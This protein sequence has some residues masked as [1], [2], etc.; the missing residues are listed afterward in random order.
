M[1]QNRW[2]PITKRFSPVLPLDH[3]DATGRFPSERS[4]PVGSS[5][6]KFFIIQMAGLLRRQKLPR[7]LFFM[8]GHFHYFASRY[9]VFD[10]IIYMR[11]CTL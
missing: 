11:T 5:L 3:C 4:R 7:H 10:I 8:I 2:H 6:I 9:S 1:C